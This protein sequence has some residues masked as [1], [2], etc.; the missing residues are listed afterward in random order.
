MSDSFF[1]NTF[2]LLSQ[3]WQDQNGDASAWSF[4]DFIEEQAAMQRELTEKYGE[5]GDFQ[6]SGA[7]EPIHNEEAN[8]INDAP[9]A[10]AVPH[11]DYQHVLDEAIGQVRSDISHKKSTSSSSRS[12]EDFSQREAAQSEVKVDALTSHEVVMKQLLGEAEGSRRDA[13]YNARYSRDEIR[14]RATERYADAEVKLDRPLDERIVDSVLLNFRND[15]I[16]DQVLQGFGERREPPNQFTFVSSE[17]VSN[18][19]SRVNF[20][21]HANQEAMDLDAALAQSFSDEQIDK[22]ALFARELQGIEEDQL[23]DDE[24]DTAHGGLGVAFGRAFDVAMSDREDGM[25]GEARQAEE[26]GF[27]PGGGAKKAT[28][29]FYQ[30]EYTGETDYI[31]E[32]SSRG[33]YMTATSTMTAQYYLSGVDE[34]AL[35][36]LTYPVAFIL[37]YFKDRK[38]SDADSKLLDRVLT[39][40]EA[41]KSALF[42][43]SERPQRQ[44]FINHR[45]KAAYQSIDTLLRAI[46]ER[47]YGTIAQLQTAFNE[48]NSMSKDLRGYYE[49]GSPNNDMIPGITEFWAEFVARTDTAISEIESKTMYE[50]VVDHEWFAKNIKIYNEYLKGKL[51]ERDGIVTDYYAEKYENEMSAMEDAAVRHEEYERRQQIR[52][53][54]LGTFGGPRVPGRVH[55]AIRNTAIGAVTGTMGLAAGLGVLMAAD[56]NVQSGGTWGPSVRVMLNNNLN[57]I[58]NIPNQWMTLQEEMQNGAGTESIRAIWR[59]AKAA[60]GAKFATTAQTVAETLTQTIPETVVEGQGDAPITQQRSKRT[61]YESRPRGAYDINTQRE[62]YLRPEDDLDSY[63]QKRRRR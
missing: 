36:D 38:T 26:K 15:D 17:D 35:D 52:D 8:Q 16:L 46:T 60:F 23:L 41:F 7:D 13:R 28:A 58:R 20:G 44:S 51:R 33:G 12:V 29:D 25:L 5:K 27:G 2:S 24:K 50:R 56:P 55:R 22:D 42:I 57:T 10:A 32:Y 1:T 6:Y 3:L 48:M 54:I 9:E 30:G 53:A 59:A 18:D 62:L 45:R 43:A 40:M 4:S 34:K 63:G 61:N 31:G 14:S 47:H 19:P 49:V 11:I 21:T 37:T 39:Q